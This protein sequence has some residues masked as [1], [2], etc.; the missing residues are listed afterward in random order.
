MFQCMDCTA[1]MDAE[2]VTEHSHNTDDCPKCGHRSLTYHENAESCC[3]QAYDMTVEDRTERFM[4][5]LE[6]TVQLE[7]EIAA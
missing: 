1:W 2:Y 6:E 5:M 3:G 4:Q 7:L